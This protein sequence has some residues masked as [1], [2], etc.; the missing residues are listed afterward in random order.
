[1]HDWFNGSNGKWVTMGVPSN[2]EYDIP[3]DII[4]GFPC[5]TENGSYKIIDDIEL[6]DFS[7]MQIQKTLQELIDEKNAIDHLL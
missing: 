3:N 2:G 1:M 6:D 4:F 7:K 5:L